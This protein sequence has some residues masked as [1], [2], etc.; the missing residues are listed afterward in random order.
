MGPAVT[1]SPV[2][3]VAIPETVTRDELVAF[4]QRAASYAK[5][6]GKAKALAEFDK[7]NGSFFEGQLYIYAYDWN[8]TTIAH[9]VNPEKIGV[10]RVGNSGAVPAPHR[11]RMSSWPSKNEPFLLSNSAELF[12]TL[13]LCVAGGTLYKGNEFISCYGFLYRCRMTGKWLRLVPWPVDS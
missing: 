8:G 13:R 10:N 7:R 6:E 3:P 11:R 5:T 12:F 9:P 1:T 4:V 2:I